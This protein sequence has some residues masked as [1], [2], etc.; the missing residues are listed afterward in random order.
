MSIHNICSKEVPQ[1]STSNENPQYTLYVFGEVLLRITHNI[2]CMSLERCFLWVSTIYIVCLWRGPSY[3]YPQYTLFVFGGCGVKF[4]DLFCNKS[5]VG[6]TLSGIIPTLF[7]HYACVSTHFHNIR[8]CNIVFL[9]STMYEMHVS[10]SV[11]I[12][13]VG[14]ISFFHGGKFE[15]SEGYNYLFVIFYVL[16]LK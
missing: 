2:H 16:E 13:T 10:I 14:G 9:A 3:E 5:L 8:R 12:K 15:K 7:W 1:R 6:A 11:T 4:S